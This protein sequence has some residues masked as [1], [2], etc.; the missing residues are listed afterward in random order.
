MIN[1][2][3]QIIDTKR[4]KQMRFKASILQSRLCDYSD[5]YL[6]VEVT[7]AVENPNNCAYHKNLT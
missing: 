4:N 2:E 1:L 5:A 3:M 7:I 6:V